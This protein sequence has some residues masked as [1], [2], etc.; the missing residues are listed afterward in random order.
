MNVYFCGT[1]QL[2]LHVT[3][4]TVPLFSKK[5]YCCVNFFSKSTPSSSFIFRYVFYFV[6]NGFCVRSE[7]FHIQHSPLI[8]TTSCS[9]LYSA[10]DD[11][12]EH[13]LWTKLTVRRHHVTNT[14]TDTELTE[15]QSAVTSYS[16][17]YT[18]THTRRDSPL[19]KIAHLH[20]KITTVIL[21]RLSFFEYRQE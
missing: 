11:S 18:H 5:K 16:T 15:E 2:C 21:T 20:G 8:N 12:L 3:H 7:C 13:V 1:F 17:T 9:S 10:A 4:M 19:L 14:V 6:I